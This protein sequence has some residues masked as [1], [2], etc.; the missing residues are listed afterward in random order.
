MASVVQSLC[1]PA[2]LMNYQYC[3]RTCHPQVCDIIGHLETICHGL[4]ILLQK[5]I[6]HI[7]LQTYKYNRVINSTPTGRA[8]NI[9]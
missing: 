4:E 2:D 1:K 3:T 6:K 9:I 7:I 5:N 8:E